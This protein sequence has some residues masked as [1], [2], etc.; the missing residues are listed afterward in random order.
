MTLVSFAP[1]SHE[2]PR[3][4][5]R[6][7]PAKRTD[8][9]WGRGPDDPDVCVLRVTPL[10]AELWPALR[11]RRLRFSNLPRRGLPAPSPSS[12][13]TARSR[14][15]CDRKTQHVARNQA[16]G[17]LVARRRDEPL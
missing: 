5:V 15:V 4:L 1:S 14:C 11:A 10:T 17:V 7:T 2:T 12:G 8:N 6:S 13:R 9:V 3:R 16:L